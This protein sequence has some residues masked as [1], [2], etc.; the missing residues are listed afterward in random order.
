MF[1]FSLSGAKL[2]LRVKRLKT[3]VPIVKDYEKH[4]I[5]LSKNDEQVHLSRVPKPG[6]EEANLHQL[7]RLVDMHIINMY[8]G[9]HI[10]SIK[11]PNTPSHTVSNPCI[12][13]LLAKFASLFHNPT[14]LPPQRPKDHK[15]NL[16]LNSNLVNVRPYR[17]PHFEKQEIESQIKDMLT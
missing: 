4:T 2:I 1:V 10:T 14:R 6:P 11:L 7:Q 16:T 13:Q 3:I 9:L 8:V 17:C 5:N 15:I 12:T